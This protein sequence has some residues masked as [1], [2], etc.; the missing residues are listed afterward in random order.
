MSDLIARALA[1]YGLPADTPLNLLN[2][3][4]NETW[5][6]GPLIL[7]LHR[8]GY[9]TKAEIASEL[10]W[11]TALQDL[12]SL[13]TVRPVPGAQGP[14][15]QVDDRFIVAFTPI[16]GQELQPGDDLGRWFGPLG[17]ITAHLHLQARGWTPPPGF[18]RKRWDVDTILGPRPHWGNWRQAQG[19]DAKGVA[20]LDRATAQLAQTLRAYGT[21]PET[22][23]LIH[24]DLRLANL[25]VDGNT[26]TAID[27]DDCGFGWWVYDLAAALSFIETDPRLPDL[28]A[29]WV[30]GYTSIA[31]LRDEDRA[32]IPTLIFLR[33]VLLTAWLATRADSDTAQAL[34]GPAY[35]LGTLALAERFLTDGLAD[36]R[37]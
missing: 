25:M 9:H 11:L 8:H 4:E 37:P 10:A 19:L 12:P 17:E 32:L 18:T 35:T 2:R 34:G 1:A 33:R 5:R 22:F 28:I 15:T 21:G 27:F 23:G 26:L 13:R 31:P 3:S 16:L 24:A 14:V 36:F 30:A 6:A 7:R 20:L 29:H